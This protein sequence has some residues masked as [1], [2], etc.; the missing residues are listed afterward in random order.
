MSKAIL[1][2]AKEKE[3]KTPNALRRDGFIPATVYGHSLKSFSVQVNAKEFSKIPHKAYSHINELELSGKDKFPVI[4]RNVHRDPVRDTYY[5]I[6]FYKINEKEKIK[7]KVALNYTG[8]SEAVVKGG[9][10]IVSQTEI[11]VQCLPM[12]IPDAIDVDLS[13]ITEI[14]QVIHAGDL[15]VT[16]GIIVLAKK[17][18]ILVKV[19]VP[20]THE[21]E[22]PKAEAA[23][24]TP[25]AGA[26]A[27][28]AGAAAPAAGGKAAP[29][30]KP[31][32]KAKK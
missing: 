31:D 22:A 28:A 10:L 3:N 32:A 20:K 21:V 24:A 11:E 16:D 7:V 8:V 6:E 19:E 15:K 2:K 5:N 9:I 27:P 30:A 12:N 17:E 18:E 4:I 13:V 29:A 14:G 23:A 26:A 25:A 1:I